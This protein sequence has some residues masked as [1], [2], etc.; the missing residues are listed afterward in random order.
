[1]SGG[2]EVRRERSAHRPGLPPS[3][4]SP[5]VRCGPGAAKVS[6]QDQDRPKRSSSV[7][8]PPGLRSSGSSAWALLE[9]AIDLRHSTGAIRTRGVERFAPLSPP[10]R[11]CAGAIRTRG[12]A[13]RSSW[14]G[15]FAPPPRRGVFCRSIEKCRSSTGETAIPAIFLRCLHSLARQ[16]HSF[17]SS[18]TL[19]KASRR[20][21][22]S[23][24]VTGQPWGWRWLAATRFHRCCR[25]RG[26]LAA[27]SSASCRWRFVTQQSAG[28]RS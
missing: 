26:C 10:T 19:R 14:V 9:R 5:V 22:R 8:R 3:G 13:I 27:S 21:Q 20:S 25:L 23:L 17:S 28:V 7:R 11:G 4:S 16:M 24:Q 12:G 15:R 1:V 2:H 6:S 18:E